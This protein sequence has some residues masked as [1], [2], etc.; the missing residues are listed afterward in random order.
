M[1]KKNSFGAFVFHTLDMR[2]SPAWRPDNARRVLD[3]LEVEHMEHAGS[4]NGALV[5]TYSDMAACGIR[6][7]SVSLAIRQ[8]V[9]LGF[10]KVTVGRRAIAQHRAPS[11]YR[12]TYVVGRKTGS[13]K[14][15]EPT[16]EWRRI[17]TDDD[18]RAA[19]AKADC[20]RNFET[21]AP[22]RMAAE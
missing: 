22:L 20:D 8:C 14:Q 13:L 2:R 17:K 12:L 21:Q 18:A 7:A 4:E 9:E 1:A 5:C 15:D 19:L 11:L 3:R 10:L 6:R 16:H